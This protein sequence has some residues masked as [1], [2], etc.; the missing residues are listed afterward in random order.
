ME[1]KLEKF[2]NNSTATH[3]TYSWTQNSTENSEWSTIVYCIVPN[4]Y[5]TQ[6]KGVICDIC[7]GKIRERA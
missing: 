1:K 4:H 3:N 5:I 6:S 7:N 2:T